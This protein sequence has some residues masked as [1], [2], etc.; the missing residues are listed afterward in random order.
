VYFSQRERRL[1]APPRSQ[2]T[3]DCWLTCSR[4]MLSPTVGGIFEASSG[5]RPPKMAFSCS[6]AVV[7]P[8]R[9]RPTMSVL[10]SVFFVHASHN[11]EISEN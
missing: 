1:L 7:L 10:Y 8:A 4:P 3:S 11:P 6:R 9:S 2:K 5:S